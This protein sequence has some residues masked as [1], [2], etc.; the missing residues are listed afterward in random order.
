MEQQSSHRREQEEQ[1]QGTG[2]GAEGGTGPGQEQGCKEGATAGEVLDVVRAS[3]TLVDGLLALA[4]AAVGVLGTAEGATC[5]MG[6]ATAAQRADLRRLSRRFLLLF[7]SHLRDSHLL[8]HC[9]RAAVMAAVGGRVV[10]AAGGSG[11]AAEGAGQG[12]GQRQGQGSQRT[13]S[14]AGADVLH[15]LLQ[16]Y[17]WSVSEARELVKLCMQ[18]PAPASTVIGPAVRQALTGPAVVHLDLVLGLHALSRADGG[19][20]YG[21]PVSYRVLPAVWKPGRAVDGH[22][23]LFTADFQ[24]MGL[25]DALRRPEL[26]ERLYELLGGVGPMLTLQLRVCELTTRSA[27]V[28]GQ[29]AGEDG[30]ERSGEE[31]VRGVAGGTL[32]YATTPEAAVGIGFDAHLAVHWL[33]G[34]C[35]EQQEQQRESAAREPGGSGGREAAGAGSSSQVAS[36]A[37]K[38][39]VAQEAAGRD[40]GLAAGEDGRE[41]AG[42]GPQEAA[43]AGPGGVREREWPDATAVSA[44]VHPGG[45]AGAAAVAPTAGA[46]GEDVAGGARS[47][48]PGG[49]A[50]AATAMPAAA[51]QAAGAFPR[52]D[53]Q[54]SGP[55]QRSRR[56]LS[57]RAL[58]AF[59]VRWWRS[60]CRV[61]EHMVP[62]RLG[63]EEAE[64]VHALRRNLVGWLRMEELRLP[65]PIEGGY[66]D[67]AAKDEC[68]GVAAEIRNQPSA[69][70][71]YHLYANMNL[72][73][74]V[75]SIGLIASFSYRYPDLVLMARSPHMVR[76]QLVWC[77]PALAKA[78]V[79]LSYSHATAMP[80][81]CNSTLEYVLPLLLVYP[82]P[83][84]AA[85]A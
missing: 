63:P 19:P 81:P 9:A 10:G 75:G 68:L 41:R 36:Q 47:G 5:A 66:Q 50:G 80:Q 71:L 1:Q 82:I 78:Y 65:N 8:E 38:A 23:G 64:T 49:A 6:A 46:S 57:L 83:Y 59:E 42:I 17:F 37:P 56:P 85:V 48:E 45:V 51:V 52:A 60:V 13:L 44:R 20:E 3:L 58:R 33:L 26:R 79:L 73:S 4:H 70:R 7:A 30:E 31:G 14:D 28:H 39:L 69:V 29:G 67:V 84:C 61:A 74:S 18:A 2:E 43:Q 72:Y 54:V 77:A 40:E 55:G 53:G 35:W 21:M 15:G 16:D 25:V 32:R 12:Q 76:V 34:E 27:E 62:L 22:W 24:V 11:E